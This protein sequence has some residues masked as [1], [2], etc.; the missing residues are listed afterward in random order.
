MVFENKKVILI[1]DGGV[2]KTTFVRK[3]LDLN[4]SPQYVPTLGVEVHPV[5]ANGIQYNVWDCAG[6]EKFEG[7]SDG[8]YINSDIAIIMCSADSKLSQRN[9]VGWI[10]DARR[11]CPDIQIVI[12][13]NKSD[14]PIKYSS[15]LENVINNNIP[16]LFYSCK[17]EEYNPDQIFSLL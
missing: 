9:L 5:I 15:V 13:L 8:Y 6:Q 2:G 14:L 1:G 3:L 11:I 4:F 17:N 10:S 16:C 7:L 12:C